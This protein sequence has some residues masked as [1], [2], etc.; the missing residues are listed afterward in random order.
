MKKLHEV[1]QPIFAVI[2]VD[3]CQV[4][5]SNKKA[6]YIQSLFKIRNLL[7]YKVCSNM[8]YEICSDKHTLSVLNL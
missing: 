1:A 3:Y 5:C 4:I 7:K 2:V 6:A 8:K